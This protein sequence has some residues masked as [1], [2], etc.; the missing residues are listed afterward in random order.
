M[1]EVAF[2]VRNSCTF[3]VAG[4]LRISGVPL[5]GLLMQCLRL[6]PFHSQ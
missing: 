2:C 4:R 1:L 5:L 6:I 3:H